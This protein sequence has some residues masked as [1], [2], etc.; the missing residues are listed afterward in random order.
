MADEPRFSPV[1][2]SGKAKKNRRSFRRA[3]VVDA[4]GRAAVA[5]EDIVLIGRGI[6]PQEGAVE[7][8]AGLLRVERLLG[9][10][11]MGA[12][13]VGENTLDVEG[14]PE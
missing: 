13:R 12:S 4:L 1:S 6:G 2:R 10:V 8:I 7:M 9:A 14:D 5:L 3:E 11:A